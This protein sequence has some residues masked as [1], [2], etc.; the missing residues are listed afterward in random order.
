[1]TTRRIQVRQPRSGK[2]VGVCPGPTD[3]GA[4]PFAGPGGV[5]PCAGFLIGPPGA[6]PRYWPLPVPAGYRH[7]DVPWNEMAAASLDK[8]EQCRRRWRAG[9][10]H[11]TARVRTLAVRGDPRYRAMSPHDLDLTALWYWRLSSTAQGLRRGE[12]RAQERAETYLAFAEHRRD[13]AREIR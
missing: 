11:R 3:A 10:R 6:D 1:M 7:C 12:K 5:V 13:T 9:L 4:C 8:A 2:I